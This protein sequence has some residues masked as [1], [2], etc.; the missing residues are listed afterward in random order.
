MKRSIFSESVLLLVFFVF[1][2]AFS[3]SVWIPAALAS[4]NLVSWTL[5]ITPL[6]VVGSFGPSVAAF[7]LTAWQDG[8]T[9]A[10]RLL[11]RGFTYRVPFTLLLFIIVVPVTITFIAFIMS[12]DAHSVL[13]PLTLLSTFILFFF[14]G[15]SFGEEFGWRGYAL[16]R[17]LHR[18]GTLGASVALGA[19]WSAWHL[20]LFW[21]RGTSQFITPFWLFFVF[22]I[23]F[24]VIFTWVHRNSAGNLFA[25][26]LLHTVF[27][28]TVVMFPLPE[29][30][31]DI[32][33]SMYYTT[34]L[35]VLVA[36][37][38]IMMSKKLASEGVMPTDCFP[39][40]SK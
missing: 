20:P 36:A 14:F 30:V 4:Q 37:F 7:I 5:P 25:A 15:G 9:G 11:K 28:L 17:L 12:S 1:A 6:L 26:L 8:A 13:N 10:W 24:S 23:A 34:G 39:R 29:Q 40:V 22:T 32:D 31:G 19:M 3:W 33:Q 27:N 16:P 21:V 35:F 38:L 2:Y 18:T